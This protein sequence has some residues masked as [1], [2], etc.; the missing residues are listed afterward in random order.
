VFGVG[1]GQ[2]YGLSPTFLT[3]ELAWT[4]GSE[5]A[6]NY[7]LQVG[8]ELGLLG[9]GLFVAWLAAAAARTARALGMEPHDWRLLGTAGGVL[10]F[11]ATSVTGHPL[12]VD[13]TSYPFWMQLGLVVGLAGSILLNHGPAAP[14]LRAEPAKAWVWRAASL[15][16]IAMVAAISVA[17]RTL[18]PPA[19]QAVDG[20]Y[21]WETGSDGVP[22]RGTGKY[23][24]LFVPSDVTHVSVPVRMP[25]RPPALMPVSVEARIATKEAG[26]TLVHDSW[27]TLD[28]T[29]PDLD[30]IGGFTRIDLR[31]D[32][33]WQP[34]LYIPGSADMRE[35]GVQVAAPRPVQ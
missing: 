15:T 33:T 27:A 12:L 2:Y 6:H 28:L 9:L 16:G 25:T 5:N 35:V 1:V 26:L 29:L 31:V 23:A 19:S 21:E 17:T 22:F 10:C 32:R 4:Y 7:F 24:S 11:I 30:P 20:F 14:G 3:P 18:E 8:A 34:A 13:E